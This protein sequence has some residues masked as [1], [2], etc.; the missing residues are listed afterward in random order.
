LESKLEA[1]PPKILTHQDNEDR[2]RDFRNHVHQQLSATPIVRIPSGENF[3]KFLRQIEPLVPSEVK[4]A[5]VF[6]RKLITRLRLMCIPTFSATFTKHESDKALD[7]IHK[8]YE[9]A[10]IARDQVAGTLYSNRPPGK[11]VP[12]EGFGIG[13]LNDA[14]S[15]LEGA[16]KELRYYYEVFHRI[17]KRD[18]DY[19]VYGVRKMV[20]FLEENMPEKKYKVPALIPR[21]FEKPNEQNSHRATPI[22]LT[23]NA[24]V[25]LGL[26]IPEHTIRKRLDEKIFEERMRS[27]E[28]QAEMQQ[29]WDKHRS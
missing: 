23:V 9:Q 18:N 19:P 5:R 14:L 22:R 10:T 21:L 16:Y 28:M 8:A 4:A 3:E 24:S 20:T 2:F 17:H 26:N 12:R 29:F 11:D 13:R 25:M 27:P 7:A 6:G 1:Q 15:S